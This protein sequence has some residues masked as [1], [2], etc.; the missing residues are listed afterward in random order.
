MNQSNDW[1]TLFD[2]HSVA[3]WRGFRTDTFPS[4]WTVENGLLRTIP[5][6]DPS[7]KKDRV[8]I[9]TKETF[10]HY[11]LELEWKVA[12][13]GNSGIFVHVSEDT[14]VIWR[15]APEMQILDDDLHPDGENSLTSAGALYDLIAPSE[16]K[17]VHP[18]G[19]FNHVR[20]E[21]RGSYV[22]HW[23][24]GV[25]LLGY[26]LGSDQLNRLIAQSKFAEY[27]NFAKF[28][29]GSVG[30]QHHGEETWFRNI[31]IKPLKQ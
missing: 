23:M 28:R 8:D 20:L 27:P 13:R 3:A 2:G 11:I 9:I 17:I 24:N 15:V 6:S 25:K 22:Q 1:I 30:L 21:V 18:V 4:I 10:S 5:I 7:Q 31:R 16:N 29:S 12:P 19:E 14:E 26:E